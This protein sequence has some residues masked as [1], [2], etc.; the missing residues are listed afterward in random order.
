LWRQC[1][2]VGGQDGGTLYPGLEQEDSLDI[3]IDL[4]CRRIEL[5]YEKDTEYMEGLTAFRYIPNP[6][7]MGA[8]DDPDPVR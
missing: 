4:M 1:D 3:F 5:S 2:E 8:H 6:N 7:A